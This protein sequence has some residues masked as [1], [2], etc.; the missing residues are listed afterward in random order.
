MNE[1][2]NGDGYYYFYSAVLQGYAALLGICLAIT[3]FGLNRFHKQFGDRPEYSNDD[4]PE[5]S[6]NKTV[7]ALIP[8]LSQWKVQWQFLPRFFVISAVLIIISSFM[9]IVKGLLCDIFILVITLIVF[10]GIVVG[11]IYLYKL[12]KKCVIE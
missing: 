10:I 12:I 6:K 7:K 11:F 5:E 4:S 9:L 1:F 8:I 2:L 3:F